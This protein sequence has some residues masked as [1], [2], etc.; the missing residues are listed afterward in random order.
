MSL[1]RYCLPFQ[2]FYLIQ[3]AD[4]CSEER[5]GCLEHQTPSSTRKKPAL[6]PSRFENNVE[7]F[8][9]SS[10]LYISGTIY[11]AYKNPN[12]RTPQPRHSSQKGYTTCD[13]PA[14]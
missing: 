6:H 9:L 5:A 1:E 12:S 10:D 13:S 11:K 2:L 7:H 3:M 8:P 14:D 4:A